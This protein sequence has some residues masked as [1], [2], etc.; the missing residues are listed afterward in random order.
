[1]Q[2]TECTKSQDYHKQPIKLRAMSCMGYAANFNTYKF[3]GFIPEW[4]YLGAAMVCTFAGPMVMCLI[5]L[6]MHM[7]L[8]IDLGPH[9]YQEVL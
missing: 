4:Q 8:K 2:A 3:L 7:F 1:M 9:E 6:T 5:T